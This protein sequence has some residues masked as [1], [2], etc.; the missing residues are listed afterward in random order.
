MPILPGGDALQGWSGDNVASSGISTETTTTGKRRFARHERA[1]IA[2]PTTPSVETVVSRH[3]RQIRQTD[4]IRSW[5]DWVNGDTQTRGMRR[6][7]SEP[8]MDLLQE[9]RA[10]PAAGC[11]QARISE[12][13]SA[14][15]LGKQKKQIKSARS[16]SSRLSQVSDVRSAHNLRYYMDSNEKCVGKQM[17]AAPGLSAPLQKSSIEKFRNFAVGLKP[18]EQTFARKH[19]LG[20]LH[21]EASKA[22]GGGDEMSKSKRA[23]QDK[24]C[25]PLNVKNS[26]ADRRSRSLP[27]RMDAQATPTS[28]WSSSYISANDGEQSHTQRSRVSQS[29]LASTPRSYQRTP[30]LSASQCSSDS[31]PH[32]HRHGLARTPRSN[33]SRSSTPRSARRESSLT[34]AAESSQVSLSATPS[35][36][37]SS[38]HRRIQSAA[39]LAS[40]STCDSQSRRSSGDF[41]AAGHLQA[42][43]ERMKQRTRM[44]QATD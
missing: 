15:S 3:K 18:E 1:P 30:R 35:H 22:E 33:V 26:T 6:S 25:A 27:P 13:Q 44:Y 11:R 43:K 24:W 28:Q 2:L 9:A 23:S 39:S 20:A 14:K 40:S 5:D 29:S 12:M 10:M 42:L 17:A 16:P 19:V 8:C 7:R 21:T 34:S 31:V 41:S 37:T 32:P 38:S 36:L 4:G